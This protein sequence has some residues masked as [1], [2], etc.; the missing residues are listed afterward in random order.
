[1]GLRE[2]YQ[3]D[4]GRWLEVTCGIALLAFSGLSGFVAVFGVV[5]SNRY[6]R[7]LIATVIFGLI[8][9]G[10]LRQALRLLQSRRPIGRPLLSPTALIGG[11]A[12]FLIGGVLLI[13]SAITERDF[14]PLIL[15][16]GILPA[17]FFSLK[18]ALERRKQSVPPNKSLERTRE[19]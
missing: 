16:L 8:C 9:W 13:A 3:Q 6:P 11:A 12:V 18:F 2:Y 4:A 14:R 17:A 7:A 10:L 5:Q 15:G 1:M 19:G